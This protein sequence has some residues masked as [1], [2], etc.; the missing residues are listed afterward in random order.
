VDQS[1]SALDL[2]WQAGMSLKETRLRSLP[3]G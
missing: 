3:T 2:A 1:L